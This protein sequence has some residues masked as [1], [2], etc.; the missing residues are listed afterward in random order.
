MDSRILKYEAILLEKNDLTLVTDGSPNSATFLEG[1]AGRRSPSHKCLD[2]TECQTKIRPDLRET[3]FQTEFHFF[4]GG[5]S[6]VV[7]GKN[8][9]PLN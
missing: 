3:P 6:Q 1:E 5:S 4:V 9:S 2:I 7:E 8:T